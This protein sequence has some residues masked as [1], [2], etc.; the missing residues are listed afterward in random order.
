[1]TGSG[2]LKGMNNAMDLAE[3][4]AEHEDLDHALETWSARQTRTGERMV[5]LARQLEEALIWSI[6]DLLALGR[7]G[8][9]KL[10]ARSGQNTGRHSPIYRGANNGA[11]EV[12]MKRSEDY[13]TVVEVLELTAPYEEFEEAVRAATKRLEAEG[14]RELVSVNFYG[15]PGSTEAGAVLTFSDRERMFDH[16]EMISSWEEFQR[17]VATVKPLDV[18]V[19]GRLHS[20]S[21]AWIKQFGD[22]VSKKFEHHTAGFV[23]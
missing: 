18:R 7:G 2:V 17:F 22:I 13:V 15:E 1:L 8:D 11:E 21:E 3:A 9:A 16:T 10:V 23:R 14:I 6:P 5:A 19:Y 20:R 12:R 4:L